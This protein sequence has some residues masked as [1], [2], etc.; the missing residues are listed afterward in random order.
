MPEVDHDRL[1]EII[2]FVNDLAVEHG[3]ATKAE[4]I[5]SHLESL[6]NTLSKPSHVKAY[7]GIIAKCELWHEWGCD[8]CDVEYPYYGIDGKYVK[9]LRKAV[10]MFTFVDSGG[11]SPAECTDYRNIISEHSDLCWSC[12][13]DY[14]IDNGVYPNYEREP[15]IKA[16]LEPLTEHS[17]GVRTDDE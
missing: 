10:G 7:K 14:L 17:P 6:T 5:T 3:H 9:E 11:F 12:A 15:I 13:E 16:L 2:E 8:I 4:E 1:Q